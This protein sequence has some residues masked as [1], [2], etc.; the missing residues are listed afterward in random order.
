MS[1]SREGGRQAGRGRAGAALP[2]AAAVPETSF[3]E[4]QREWQMTGQGR[5]HT[6]RGKD[7]APS[8]EESWM[9]GGPE[10]A[11]SAEILT[12][13]RPSKKGSPSLGATYWAVELELAGGPR[14]WEEKPFPFPKSPARV[15]LVSAPSACSRRPG[16]R[17]AFP[18]RRAFAPLTLNQ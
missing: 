11:R 13:R 7:Q 12:R 3:T 10:S 14:P 6:E 4:T 17:L 15:A 18:A 5:K 9:K 1:E 2:R 8:R 16:A